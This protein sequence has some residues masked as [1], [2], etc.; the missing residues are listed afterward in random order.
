MSTASE[1]YGKMWSEKEYIIVLQSYYQYKES[2]QH[3]DTPFI[4]ELSDLLGRTPHSILYR[5]QNFTSIDPSVVDPKRKGKAHITEFGR[6]IFKKWSDNREILKETANAFLRDEKLKLEPDLF[7]PNPIRIPITFNNYELLD[8]IGKGNFGIVCSCLNTKTDKVYALKV[9]DSSKIY[10]KDC[11]SRFSREIK[12]LKSVEHPNI[13]QI[14]EDNL[15]TQRDYP[16]FVMDLADT[17]L[18]SFLGDSKNSNKTSQRPLLDTNTAKNILMSIL[19]AVQTLHE[20]S[21]PIIHRDINPNNILRKFDGEWALAD[22]S[23]AKFLPPSPTSTTFA[24]KTHIGMGTGHYTAPEQYT[25]LKD[26]DVSSDIYSLGWLMW[27]LFSSEGPFPRTDPSGLPKSLEDI[28]LKA[29]SY[30]KKDRYSSV[31]KMCNEITAALS[32]IK[33]NM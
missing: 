3:A 23:L 11:V 20:S 27:E 5:L 17:D 7:N 31:I 2:P 32:T 25:S 19:N 26:A 30:K 1:I 24:T 16:G 8:E 22:F 14:H 10:D 9:I 13:I 6:R 4:R 28:F 12:A 33:T 15:D 29:V 21:P 18:S